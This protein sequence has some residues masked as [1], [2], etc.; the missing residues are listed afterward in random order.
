MV[1]YTKDR[2]ERLDYA[3]DFAPKLGNGEVLSSIQ[4][5][6]IRRLTSKTDVSSEFGDPAATALISGDE[7]YF[8]LDEAS[9]SS[10]Q[11]QSFYRVYIR[12]LT[13][14]NDLKTASRNAEGD[15]PLL[16]VHQ[17]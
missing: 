5:L 11:N 13:S 10:Y 12:V 16:R 2:T 9:Q 3:H 6:E 7:V 14:D 17:Q 15:Y 4:D 8:E 1:E